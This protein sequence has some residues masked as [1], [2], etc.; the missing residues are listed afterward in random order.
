MHVAG[1]K[2]GVFKRLMSW[3]FGPRLASKAHLRTS[4]AARYL[5]WV[6]NAHR[7]SWPTRKASWIDRAGDAP[8]LGRMLAARLK[9]VAAANAPR[10]RSAAAPKRA[11]PAGKAI[12]KKATRVLKRRKVARICNYAAPLRVTPAAVSRTSNVIAFTCARGK[13]MVI[14]SPRRQAA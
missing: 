8:S 12:P 2:P 4:D 1:A 6:F 7:E 10:S 9:S 13:P 14:P 3:I 11:A 5:P